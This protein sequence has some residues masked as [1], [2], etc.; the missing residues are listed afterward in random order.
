L[1]S[2]FFA[3]KG[4][5]DFGHPS[6]TGKFSL[7]SN[8]TCPRFVD[9]PTTGE[10]A[11]KKQV[12]WLAAIGAFGLGGLANAE[13]V[14]LSTATS[15][16]V[17]KASVGVTHRQA[18]K[19]KAPIRLTDMQMDGVVAGKYTLDPLGDSD[20]SCNSGKCSYD[21]PQGNE[22]GKPVTGFNN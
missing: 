16:E 1:R 6:R 4:I 10:T 21:N 19:A 9:G 3:R 18:D 15:G 22:I 7:L 11:M 5:G 20:N 8:L 12:M 2:D 14:K 17:G 13:P